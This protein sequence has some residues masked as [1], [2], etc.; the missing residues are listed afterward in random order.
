MKEKPTKRLVKI[1]F[2]FKKRKGGRAT[3]CLSLFY[4]KGKK[5]CCGCYMH[6]DNGAVLYSDA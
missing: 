6:F 4:C 1:P 3:E 5:G 2:V